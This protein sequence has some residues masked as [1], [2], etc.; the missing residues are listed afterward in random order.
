MLQT[1]HQI[2]SVQILPSS[3]SSISVAAFSNLLAEEQELLI[4]N[5]YTPEKFF[6]LSRENQQRLLA[7][8][9]DD[10]LRRQADPNNADCG[11]YAAA[12]A[13]VD[14]ADAAEELQAQ[15]TVSRALYFDLNV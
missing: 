15:Q 12:L 8:F 4:Y 9:R 5:G 2:G 13:V 11:A 6:A 10:A 1:V 3:I 7:V 14:A